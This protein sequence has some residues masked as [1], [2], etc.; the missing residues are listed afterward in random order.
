MNFT[1]Q[2]ILYFLGGFILIFLLH[3]YMYIRNKKVL[4]ENDGIGTGF[5]IRR[6]N[7]DLKKI[8][9]KKVAIIVSL[10]NSLIISFTS[11]IV[12]NIDN[13]IYKILVGFV[14]IF[15][16]IFSLYEIVGRYLYKSQFK[17]KEVKKKKVKKNVRSHKNRK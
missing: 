10:V 11:V 14:L 17:V 7:L 9:Y 8:T 6:F 13:F 5:V 4:K 1:L 16:L 2:S 15:A 12:I 3:F